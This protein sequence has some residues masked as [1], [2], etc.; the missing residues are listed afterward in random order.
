MNRATSRVPRVFLLLGGLLLAY[1]VLPL[2]AFAPRVATALAGGWSGDGLRRA[3][4]VSVFTATV[5]TVLLAFL[6][7]PLAYVLARRD[8]PGKGVAGLLVQAPLAL[9]P[10]VAGILLLMTF[11]PYTALGALAASLGLR[12]TDSLA[13]IVLAQMFV[14]SPFLVIAAR[15]AFESVDPEL[16][17]VSA[18]LGKSGWETLRRV[19]LPLA[20][21]GILGGMALCWVRALGEFG[22]TDVMAYHPYSLPVLTWVEFSGSGL[23]G[24]LPLTLVQLTL[25]AAG[26]LLS[27]RLAR[28]KIAP[29]ERAEAPPAP[30]GTAS[31]RAAS[32]GEAARP[33]SF[34]VRVNL[35]LG[36]FRL[37]AAFA[38][39][40]GRVAVLGPSGS[41]KSVLLK[42]L[43]GLLKPENGAVSISGR[44]LFDSASGVWLPAE[45][46]GIGYVPQN[47]A[48]FPHMTVWE[49]VLFA[50]KPGERD[51]D[52]ASRI[53]RRLGLEGL[54]RR[55]PGQLSYGQQQRVALARA[56]VR[57][58]RVLLL[59]EPFA[60][61]DSH[62]RLRLRRELLAVLSTLDAAVVLV[63]HDAEE[64]YELAEEVVVL[65][66][67][68]VIQHGSREEVFAAPRSAA[69]AE[70]LGLRNVFNGRV[71][72]SEP[73]GL[74]IRYQNSSLM[75]P[76]GAHA[77]SAD[78]GFFVSPKRLSLRETAEPLATGTVLSGEVETVYPTPSGA[79]LVVAVGEGDLREFWEVEEPEPAAGRKRGERV[80]LF[81]PE[82]AV[83]VMGG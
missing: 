2:V 21:P 74:V 60:S 32:A 51:P 70:L 44:V 46:R 73:R 3:A 34:D 20:W 69:A 6:G 16:E 40:R 25:G 71:I 38:S 11:G 79:R 43:A 76:P 1:S 30:S 5:S 19:T 12:L 23:S 39:R 48:L 41:G 64:A 61:L 9:P 28:W 45:T 50:F 13:G 63:T 14:S 83:R 26:L 35:A 59:D 72:A 55:T 47:L 31:G 66:A 53:L 57:E 15:S 7:I 10:V 67:G 33:A 22:A 52:A 27:F 54:W 24:A 49:Q 78:V 18:T 80:H 36:D 17:A 75:A 37:D 77:P 81:V 62:L 68:A 42:T 4:F 65:S 58:P 29:G 56:L 8:F 82:S